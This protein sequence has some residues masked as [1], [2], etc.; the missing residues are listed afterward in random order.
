MRVGTC[1]LHLTR[2]SSWPRHLDRSSKP[3]RRR[4]LSSQRLQKSIGLLDKSRVD[5][6]T[7]LAAVSRGTATAASATSAACGALAPLWR[8]L[9]R[10]GQLAMQRLLAS[11][12]NRLA[13]A[14]LAVRARARLSTPCA[15]CIRA[16]GT[17]FSLASGN[18]A[19]SASRSPTL[20][21][22]ELAAASIKPCSDA[23]ASA[24]Q[25]ACEAARRSSM[26]TFA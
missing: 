24:N 18:A 12:R 23:T 22:S 11:R 7:T 3:R 9:P 13:Q 8:R 26:I 25:A 4:I 1:C 14:L 20:A 16:D 10:G 2:Q 19:S 17:P 15:S 6:A 21:P 5:L